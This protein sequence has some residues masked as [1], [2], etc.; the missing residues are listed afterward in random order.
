MPRAGQEQDPGGR[1][2]EAPCQVR[3]RSDGLKA[4]GKEGAE[5]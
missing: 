3:E 2:L 1:V 5:D 4:E